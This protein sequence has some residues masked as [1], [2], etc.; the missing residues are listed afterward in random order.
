MPSIELTNR[1]LSAETGVDGHKITRGYFTNADLAKLAAAA[2]NVAR[3][4][5]YV[6]DANL[7]IDRIAARS[8]RIKA[9]RGLDVIFID[10]LQLVA[11]S[12]RWNTREQEVSEVSRSLKALAKELNV[13][14][15]AG[16]QLNRAI[17]TRAEKKPTLAD[18]RESGAIEQDADAVLF[19]SPTNEKGATDLIIAKHRQGPTGAVKLFF[20]KKITRFYEGIEN[21]C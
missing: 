1:L 14:V 20:N 8:R 13:P 4:P 11:P 21:E 17:E 18:L 7:P 6:D 10:Y 19:L 16:A 15:I 12:H 9:D 3:L 2:D 5:L